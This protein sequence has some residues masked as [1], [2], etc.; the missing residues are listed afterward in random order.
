VTLDAGASSRVTPNVKLIGENRNV[1]NSFVEDTPQ[2]LVN[3]EKLGNLINLKQFNTN[4]TNKVTNA[5]YENYYN[6]VF[7]KAIGETARN[8]T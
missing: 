6:K 5:L 8:D 3:A 2:G 7:P 1:F 4:Q